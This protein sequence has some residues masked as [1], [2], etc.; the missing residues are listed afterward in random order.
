MSNLGTCAHEA[1][2]FVKSLDPFW[3]TREEDMRL[4]IAILFDERT[5][6]ALSSLRDRLHDASESGNFVTRDNLH[7]TLEFLGE[8]DSS[9]LP[10]IERVLEN[11]TV[12]PMELK[13]SSIGFFPG[14][15]WWAGIE[16]NKDLIMLQRTLHEALLSEGFSLEKRAYRPH[17]TLG[18]KVVSNHPSGRIGEFSTTVSSVSLM[19][20][21]RQGRGM[22][23]TEL[24]RAEGK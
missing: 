17:V 1:V 22:K 5:V 14:G 20:S 3:L 8:C 11:L 13:F 10:V 21:E 15:T 19:L 4:F 12:R 6:D 2:E 16:R 7:L 18:R 24:Y 9:Q 23:Y